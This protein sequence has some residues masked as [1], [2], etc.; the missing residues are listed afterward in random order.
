MVSSA[1]YVAYTSPITLQGIMWC[2]V[3]FSLFDAL[4]MSWW[5]RG[6]FLAIRS[7]LVANEG[8]LESPGPPGSRAAN[9][10]MARG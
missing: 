2:I 5:S 9:A 10:G 8:V 1:V 4:H 7:P 3:L 6:I